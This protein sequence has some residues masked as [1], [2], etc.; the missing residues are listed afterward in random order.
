MPRFAVLAFA[1]LLLLA[2]VASALPA[3]NS[4]VPTRADKPLHLGS[5]GPY[6]VFQHKMDA[7]AAIN[8]CRS[9][10]CELPRELS[11]SA[12]SCMN[13]MLGPATSGWAAVNNDGCFY[14]QGADVPHSANSGNCGVSYNHA[15]CDCSKLPPTKCPGL[16][17]LQSSSGVSAAGAVRMCAEKGCS[18]AKTLTESE[19]DCVLKKV[20]A[21]VEQTIAW[22]Q[23]NITG[24][25]RMGGLQYPHREIQDEC[26]SKFDTA[27][28]RCTT[29]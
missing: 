13:Q 11:N 17:I 20:F 18:M 14:L 15:V 23:V 12:M 9:A 25:W 4:T 27:I 22:V 5:C 19:V 24:C 7:G 16:N 26:S 10:G 1:T 8:V 21:R 28:C 3:T 29:L 6:H 2:S